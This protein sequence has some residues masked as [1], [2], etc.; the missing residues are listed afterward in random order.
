MSVIRR[1]LIGG[2]GG[3]FKSDCIMW[4]RISPLPMTGQMHM[5]EEKMA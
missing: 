4:L 5:F 3:G 2:Q 1:D